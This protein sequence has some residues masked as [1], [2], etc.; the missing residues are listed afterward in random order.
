M[1][2]AFLIQPLG[3]VPQHAQ[4]CAAWAFNEWYTHRTIPFAAVQKEYQR[5]ITSDLPTT[6]AALSGKTLCGMISLREHDLAARPDLSPWLSG[7]YVA[8]EFRTRGIGTKLV[9]TVCD[10]A[11]TRKYRTLYLFLGQ[12]DMQMLEQFY[13][14]RGFAFLDTACDNDGR[15]TKIFCFDFSD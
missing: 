10:A 11:R 4:Q 14:M 9:K 7:L 2:D 3:T 8:P 5:R 1:T 13:R 12:H 15:E 6:W